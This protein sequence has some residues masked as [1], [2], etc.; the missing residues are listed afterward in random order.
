MHTLF[1][2]HKWKHIGEIASETRMQNS[3]EFV[4]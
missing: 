1:R 4:I 2:V 3:V